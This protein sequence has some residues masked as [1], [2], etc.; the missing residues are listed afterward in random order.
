MVAVHRSD[1]LLKVDQ[2]PAICTPLS[3]ADK[4]V[5]KARWNVM[6]AHGR[7]HIFT[8]PVYRPIELIVLNDLTIALNK[9]VNAVVSLVDRSLD[10]PFEG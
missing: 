4:V 3:L 5:S 1:L 6:T 7:V 9:E 8:R 10:R 2:R